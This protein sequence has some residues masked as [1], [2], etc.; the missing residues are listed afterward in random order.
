MDDPGGRCTR[1]TSASHDKLCSSS[2]QEHA[3]NGRQFGALDLFRSSHAHVL[4]RLLKSISEGRV[5]VQDLRRA[6]IA[7][8][9]KLA[10]S[11]PPSSG[12]P[13]A[14]GLENNEQPVEST[15]SDPPE[16][17]LR[18]AGSCVELRCM[19]WACMSGEG[20]SSALDCALRGCCFSS[21]SLQSMSLLPKLS[22]WLFCASLEPYCMRHAVSGG[23]L[24]YSGVSP[25]VELAE[26]LLGSEEDLSGK[27]PLGGSS[28]DTRH[29]A[30]Q[31]HNAYDVEYDEK[32]IFA[33]FRRLALSPSSVVHLSFWAASRLL[34]SLPLSEALQM[35][36]F[37]LLLQ[38]A[39]P[40][41]LQ[42][43]LS[44]GRGAASSSSSGAERRGDDLW[45]ERECERAAA[46]QKIVAAVAI[47]FML[48]WASLVREEQKQA[49]GAGG[50]AVSSPTSLA[51]PEGP[52]ELGDSAKLCAL[53]LPPWISEDGVSGSAAFP[54]GRASPLCLESEQAADAL[55]ELAS[56]LD[57][58][59]AL[60]L[61]VAFLGGSSP[62][63]VCRRG[64]QSKDCADSAD[65]CTRRVE[66]QGRHPLSA[67]PCIHVDSGAAAAWLSWVLERSMADTIENGAPRE[68]VKRRG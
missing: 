31:I 14:R 53:L 27:A 48:W 13:A 56:L 36:T 32:E 61:R 18:E 26:A 45:E 62:P 43:P 21:Y 24:L 10:A 60:Y 67:A 35:R 47:P 38:T 4:H 30:E 42:R 23:P 33:A 58:P 15:E 65:C 68:L 6:V 54:M 49:E 44:S 1:G 16:G 2:P 66:S 11:A 17:L 28:S 40:C 22:V 57:V 59:K 5:T 46:A 51:A 63:G 19:R 52:L 64:L 3:E 34:L 50:T 25:A 7:K 12:V 9:R 37:L 20:L 29:R 8:R 55:F 39:A 41:L